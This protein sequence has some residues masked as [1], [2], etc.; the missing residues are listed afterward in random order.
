MRF[1]PG[2]SSEKNVRQEMPIALRKTRGFLIGGSVIAFCG[3]VGY[4]LVASLQAGETA[5]VT[6]NGQNRSNTPVHAVIFKAY[7]G[8]RKIAT[9]LTN[10]HGQPV[11]ASCSSCH[12]T[13]KANIETRSSAQLDQ[14][15]QGL[16]YT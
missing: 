8:P 14:F 5:S 10:F 6:T 9:G 2:R 1:T 11:T 16:K 4:L 3:G 15:H 12:A 7:E 13:T